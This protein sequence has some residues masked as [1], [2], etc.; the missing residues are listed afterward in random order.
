MRLEKM[1]FTICT[2]HQ[3]FL[4]SKIMDEMGGHGAGFKKKRNT[5]TEVIV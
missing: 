3:L 2:L 5:H 4:C 1:S